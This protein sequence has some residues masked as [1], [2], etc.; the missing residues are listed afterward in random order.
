MSEVTIKILWLYDDL[1]DL[2]GDSGSL[3]LLERRIQGMGHTCV[4]LLY[5]SRCV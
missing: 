3:L 1:L 4:C 5:T 2:Y